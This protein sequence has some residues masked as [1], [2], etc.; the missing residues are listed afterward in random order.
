MSDLI[1]IDGSHGE[2][3]GQMLR[4]AVAMSILTG[5]PFR[6]SDIRAGR[7]KPGLKAQHMHVLKAARRLS[8]AAVTGADVGSSMVTFAPGMPRGA[9]FEIDIGTAGSITLLMQTLLPV[10]LFA[11][12]PSDVT[13][14]GG[15]D[16]SM[17]PT[18]DY[19][20]HVVLPHARPF[21]EDITVECKRRG[22]YPRGGGEVRIA[23]RPR[24]GGGFQRVRDAVRLAIPPFAL[25]DAVSTDR[26][27]ILGVASE[28][29]RERGVADRMVDSARL[30][31]QASHV[32]RSADYVHTSS[33]GA[34]LTL[35]VH[36]QGGGVMGADALGELGKPAEKVGAQAV[37][38]LAAQGTAPVDVHLADHLVPWLALRG[39]AFRTSEFSEHTRTNCWIVEQFL[40]PLFVLDNDRTVLRAE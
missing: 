9:S 15:T 30:I 39:G 17:S 5:K 6:M 16:V 25:T 8:G 18:F 21:A 34:A 23:I 4:T 19:F 35:V 38:R 27:V 7:A 26:V 40:G 22:F 33:T 14:R 13:I 1:Q 32:E 11:E 37:E 12:G 20:R 28:T 36:Q 3:G 31:L 10:L 29:L 2:G 24:F